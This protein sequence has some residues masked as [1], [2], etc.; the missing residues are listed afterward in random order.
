MRN[1]LTLLKLHDVR[2][3]LLVSFPARVCQS[4][5]NLTIFFH[6][7]NVTSSITLAGFASG[8]YQLSLSLS[9][10]YRALLIEKF[11]QQRPL[12][13]LV[14]LYSLMVF[15]YKYIDSTILLVTLPLFMGMASPPINLS[16]RPLWK[17]V[18]T[19]DYL[20]V[21]YA[22]DST[23]MN[24]AFVIG[25]VLATS[26]ALSS[27]PGSALATAS[28]LMFIGGTA[29]GLSSI[30]RNWIPEKKV[31]GAVSLLRSKPLQLLM[32]EGCFI[33]FG[34]GLFEVAVPAFATLEGVP[35]RTAW[36][37]A[38]MGIANVIGGLLAGLVSKNRSALSTMR[39][40]YLIWFFVSIPIAFTYPGWS[41]AIFGAALGLVGGAIQVFYWE[42]M[43]A[44]RPKGSQTAALG[45]LW[46]VEGSFMAL[47]AALG[48]Y[49]S[50][51]FSPRLV[52]ATTSVCIGLGFIV[53]SLGRERLKEADRIPESEED[54]E[55]MK[56]NLPTIN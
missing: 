49:L 17:D 53:L 18:V 7:E 42:V 10:G 34:W 40:T 43:E 55:A 11:G 36:I 2:L 50:E 6:V 38:S 20:R 8:C 28:A 39:K 47:G 52:L 46:S 33:G 13:M 1:Y 27:H 16:V 37:F 22:A 5:V 21:A 9:L 4:M 41:M 12:L 48:G 30:S 32:I 45:W 14:P 3:L 54:L 44:V 19:P 35:Q 56:D 26:L 31:K 24:F 29:L 23:M 15:S 25:P 51:L